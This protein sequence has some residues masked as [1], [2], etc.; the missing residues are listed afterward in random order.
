L[1]S[2]FVEKPQVGEGWINGGFCVL[3]PE[4]LTYIESDQT[5]FEREPLERLAREGKLAAYRH[6]DFWQCMDTI[7]DVKLLEQLWQTG[8]APWKKW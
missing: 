5:M 7:R 2:E 8:K 3:E 4:V 6:E 1:V